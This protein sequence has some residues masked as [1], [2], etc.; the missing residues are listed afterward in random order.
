[1]KAD[2]EEMEAVVE[3]NQEEVNAMDLESS[4]VEKWPWRSI[5]KYNEETS[6]EIIRARENRYGDRH[7]AVGR[8]RQLKKRTQNDGG[9]WKKL[10]A[11]SDG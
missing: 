10:A 2:L 1:M 6:L 7:L 5:R 4:A 9:S 3:T 11:A 8:C